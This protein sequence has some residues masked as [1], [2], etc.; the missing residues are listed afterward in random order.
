MGNPCRDKHGNV[1]PSE[2]A[3]ARAYGLAPS[4]VAYH[5]ETHGNLDRMA[6]LQRHHYGAIATSK[7]FEIDGRRWASHSEL[8]RKVGVDRVTVGRWLKHNRLDLIRRRLEAA[9]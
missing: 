1:W 3:C 9:Q 2:S 4:T 5:L 7:P 6:G 8:A